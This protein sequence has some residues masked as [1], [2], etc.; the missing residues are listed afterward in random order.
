M[1]YQRQAIDQVLARYKFEAT[2]LLATLSKLKIAEV[3]R[4]YNVCMYVSFL[5]SLSIIPLLAVSP[6]QAEKDDVGVGTVDDMGTRY[7]ES[8]VWGPN[9]SLQ[10]C[11]RLIDLTAA[12]IKMT[13]KVL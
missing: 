7:L 9:P 11:Q 3:G 13:V 4:Y 12:K 5:N 6:L 8:K 1:V 2:N 10:K